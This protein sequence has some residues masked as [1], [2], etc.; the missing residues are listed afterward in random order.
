[1]ILV[2]TSVWVEH[3]RHGSPVLARLL[4]NGQVLGHPW[5]LGELALR[6]LRGRREVLA[7]LS[8]L[9]QSEVATPPELMAFIESHSLY[10]RGIGFVDVQLLAAARLTP[11]ARLWTNDKRLAVAASSLGVQADLDG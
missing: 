5:V 1:M 3:L 10:G 4:D 2:D 11:D 6:Q 8:Q 7:L 9:P